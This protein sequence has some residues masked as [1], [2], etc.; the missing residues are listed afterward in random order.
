MRSTFFALSAPAGF[1]AAAGACAPTAGPSVPPPEP[2]RLETPPVASA[3]SPP[4][5]APVTAEPTQ[6]TESEKA[7]DDARMPLALAILD[8]Y[9]SGSPQL[10]SDGTHFVFAS[11]RDGSRQYYLAETAHPSAPP[12]QLT[13]GAD[14]AAAAVLSRDGRSL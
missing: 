10:T 6:R 7:R 14:R 4:P 12:L 2:P 13:R 1:V 3:P 8:A 9:T 11:R 5:S